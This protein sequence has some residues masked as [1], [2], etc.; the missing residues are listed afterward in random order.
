[1][2]DGGVFFASLTATGCSRFE[3]VNFTNNQ[4]LVAGGAI[5][6]AAH[7]P[8][9]CNNRKHNDKNSTEY[10]FE[11][12]F[13]KN[14]AGY[15]PD[16]ATGPSVLKLENDKLKKRLRPSEDFDA[17]FLV[18]DYFGQTLKGF[19]DVVVN[20]GVNNGSV[21]RGD[22]S[23]QP[24]RDGS[25]SFQGLRWGDEPGETTSIL[26]YSD[27]PTTETGYRVKINQ[28]STGGTDD[29]QVLYERKEGLE[30]EEEGGSSQV[31]VWYCLTVQDPDKV[32]SNLTY[33]GVAIVLLLSF[34][35]LGL[36]FWKRDSRPIESGLLFRSRDW[37]HAMCGLG[38]HVD[39]SLRLHLCS[40]R[41]ASLS[42]Y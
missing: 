1:V 5:Y 33:A 32:A 7:S 23:K 6:F 29:D 35:F 8:P 27:P 17:D 3:S 41:L 10:C 19:I 39:Q 2:F 25:V 34:L 16:Y 42:G 28:C 18:V 13:S 36:L 21:L 15:G 4:A 14:E 20:I 40:Q 30:E 11:C 38:L 9:S 24:E 26:F 37:S 31:M 12:E 22:P